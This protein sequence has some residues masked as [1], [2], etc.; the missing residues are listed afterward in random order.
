VFAYIGRDFKSKL[1]FYTG[2]GVEGRLT[3]AD[4]I[5]ILEE[6]IA[7]KWDSEWVLLEDNDQAHGTRGEADN[8]VKRAKLRLGIKWEANPPESPDLNPIETIWRIIKQ[9]LK[10]RGLFLNVALLR[11]AIQEE[12][13]KITLEEINKVINTMPDRV[14]ALRRREGVPIPF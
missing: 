2:S 3:Q 8:K 12:W 7:P 9:R 11:R 10:S 4:Y 14:A 6:V 13:D 5:V 1:H